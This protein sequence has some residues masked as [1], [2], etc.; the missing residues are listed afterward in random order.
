MLIM[1]KKRANY[2]DRVIIKYYRSETSKEMVLYK[3]VR[4]ITGN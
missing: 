1:G 2:K 4:L 3:L